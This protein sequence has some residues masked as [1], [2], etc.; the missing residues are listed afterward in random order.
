MMQFFAG[1]KRLLRRVLI[2]GS[3]MLI[4]GTIALSALFYT[5]L[6]E[7][8]R[9]GLPPLDLADNVSPTLVDRDRKLLR[10]FT[11]TDGRWRLPVSSKDV[12][13]NYLRL[14][15]A[16]EDRRFNDH[17]GIDP[18]A[19]VRAAWQ[20]AKHRRVISG[21]ST[22]TMQVARLLDRRYQRSAR[23]KFQQI[24]R[25]LQLEAQLSKTQILNLY[26]TLAPFGGNIE[27]VRAASLA[28]FGKEPRR[29]S[30]GE[31]SLLVALPQSPEGRRPDRFAKA[32]RRSR[33][34]VLARAVAAGVISQ[35]EADRAASEPIPKHRKEFPKLAAHFAEAML[36]VD[37][38]LAKGPTTLRR[39]LQASL[40]TLVKQHVVVQGKRLSAAMMVVDHRTGEVLARV[41][42]SDYFNNNR[43]GSID[44]TTAVRSPG[45]A[46]KP[47]IY[48]LAFDYGIAHPETL[49]EDKP[50]RFGTYAPKNFD[51]TYRGTITLTEAL[52]K[53]LNV[54][55][56]KLL[57][58]V[59]A[60]RFVGRLRKA[61]TPLQ[62]PN[63]A[64][65]S[66]AVALGGVGLT[67]DDMAGLYAALARGGEPIALKSHLAD[68]ADLDHT[69]GNKLKNRRVLSAKAAHYVTQILRQATPPPNARRGAI[70]YKTGTSYGHR[71]AW[72]AGYDG[73][74]TIIVWIGRPDAATT[75]GLLG[76]T[77][78][79]PILFDAFARISPRRAAFPKAP[80]G[81]LQV[82][83]AEL[84][85]P[86]KR[87]D[88]RTARRTGGVYLNEPVR[89]A[90]PPDRSEL[91]ALGSDDVIILK[92]RGG[93]LP[94]TWF[95]DGTPISA[96]PRQRQVIWPTKRRGFVRL[97]VTDAR[98][99]TDSVVV[100]LRSEGD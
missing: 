90:F 78:A 87:F 100:R 91:A 7:A 40:E 98:G 92:S 54:P 97:S 1:H 69:L 63:D 59:G 19:M 41:G 74:H 23:A 66:L 14:L 89:I 18:L 27:G 22:L 53:S 77:A 8:K 67:L 16:F 51:K 73:R 47:F 65:P 20:L 45:S 80:E 48:G 42:S 21:G 85:E 44:M 26:L 57:D 95:A 58:A 49:I 39:L 38:K 9:L 17:W 86:L 84:P 5:G 70:A 32:A 35:P 76:R 50:S 75:P 96:N 15:F 94:L 4:V 62:L 13:Q 30:L 37:P 46:L 79:A 60:G 25:A 11:T 93:A 56:V 43:F 33:S 61:G 71:D 2:P 81:V 52:G 6:Q 99:E 68:Q 10:A 3:V 34:R 83:G 36:R 72:A 88:R 64:E 29:L 82:S 24:V 55:A 12:D 28:Y 31:A